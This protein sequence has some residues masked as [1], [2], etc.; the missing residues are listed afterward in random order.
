MFTPVLAKHSKSLNLL[1]SISVGVDRMP[2]NFAPMQKEYVPIADQ[3][4]SRDRWTPIEIEVIDRSSLV[5]NRG[6][7]VYK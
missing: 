1:D 6:T 4:L 2:R 7:D 3:S 5:V